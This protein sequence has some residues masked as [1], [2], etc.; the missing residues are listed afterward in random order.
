MGEVANKKTIIITGPMASGKTTLAKYLEKE[1]G[2]TRII[3]YTTR[4][5]RDGEQNGVDYWFVDDNTFDTMEKS[6]AFA[7]TQ[8][9]NADF[10]FCR[11][12]SVWND[13]ISDGLKVI[14]LDPMGAMEVINRYY[15][16]MKN[17][18]NLGF[19]KP[20]LVWL[21][22]PDD[23]TVKRAIQRGDSPSE[24]YRRNADD[25]KKFPVLKFGS[26]FDIRIR[27]E[28][29]IEELAKLVVDRLANSSTAR[30]LY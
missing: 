11:Y 8:S 13:Y 3:T 9:Y 20:F 18:L 10:G 19:E 5:M 28:Y 12:G 22:L 25:R 27:N 21:D 16:G 26:Y 4:P 14:V 6:N 17:Q 15:D 24:V 23:I 7:E 2:F 1:Y 30:S 29:T